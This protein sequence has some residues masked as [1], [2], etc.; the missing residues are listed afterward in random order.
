MYRDKAHRKR[1]SGHG[2]LSG[3]RSTT[4]LSEI[5]LQRSALGIL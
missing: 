2:P 4:S 1:Q 5:D 3:S